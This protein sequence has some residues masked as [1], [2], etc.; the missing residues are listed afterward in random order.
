MDYWNHIY[1]HFDPVAFNIFSLPV[2]WYGMMYV[3]A[4]VTALYI[5]KLFI[6]KDN[7]TGV[8]FHPE[9]S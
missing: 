2:H 3:L 1:D 7:F 6:K 9:K 8:Q 5:G 4:L